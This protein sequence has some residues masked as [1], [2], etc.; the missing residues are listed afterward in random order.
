MGESEP[1]LDQIEAICQR[2]VDR[3]LAGEITIAESLQLAVVEIEAVIAG[4]VDQAVDE[5]SS[6]N[7]EHE[8]EYKVDRF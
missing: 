7:A 5:E 1:G 2:L 8:R 4:L 3:T 6:A